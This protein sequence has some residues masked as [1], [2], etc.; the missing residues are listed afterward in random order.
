MKNCGTCSNYDDCTTCYGGFFSYQYDINSEKNNCKA[1]SDGIPG[2]LKCLNG[3]S[4]I[5]CGESHRL[6]S[7]GLC[8]NRDGSLV[9]GVSYST[10]GIFVLLIIIAGF[11]GIGIILLG[12][13]ATKRYLNSSRNERYVNHPHSERYM[14]YPLN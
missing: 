3:Q 11:I 7:D 14:I 9:D 10:E 1:C 4:C 8:H 13:F 12:Y 2:C 6:M 5:L